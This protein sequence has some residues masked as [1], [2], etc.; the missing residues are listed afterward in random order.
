MPI[1]HEI[2]ASIWRSGQRLIEPI[3][4]S[5]MTKLVA[6]PTLCFQSQNATTKPRKHEEYSAFGVYKP[7]NGPLKGADGVFDSPGQRLV[8]VAFQGEGRAERDAYATGPRHSPRMV[9]HA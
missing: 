2:I 3:P 5:R 4:G 1:V 6:R 8:V 9:Q 7:E